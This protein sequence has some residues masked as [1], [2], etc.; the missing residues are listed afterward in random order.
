[1]T[2]V[3]SDIKAGEAAVGALDA[4]DDS[5][6]AEL[7]ARAQAGGVKLTG[8]GGLL[9]ELTRK[10]LESA[11]EGELTDHL[12]HEPG[13]R[14]EGGRENYRNGHRSK[15]VTTEVGPVEIAVPRDRAGTFE[16]QLVKK[17]Q[18]R[19]GGVD[20]MVL[21]LSA[22]GLTHGEISA[23]L[24]E[25]YGTEV[26]KTT[27]STI[28][29]SVMAGMAEWQNRPLDS[30]YPVVFIDCVNVKVRDGQVANR[31][32]YMALAVTAEGHR[33]ILGLWV[34]DG[35]EGAKYWLQV[36]TE[37]KNRGAR[38]VLMLVCDGLTG[39][40]DAVNTVWPA[41]IVQTC[42][43]HLLRNSFRYAARQD[44]EK[45][46]KA[47]KP[48]YTAPTEDAALER[49]MEFNEAW[50]RKY[51]A[52]VRLWES[53][54]AEFVPFLQFDIEIRKIVC[55]TNAIES[56][57]ARIRKAVRARGHFPTEQAALKCVY[58]AVMSLDPKGTG[59]KRWTMR[60]KAALQAFDIT[61]DGRLT[62]GRR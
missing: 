19:L 4:V 14:V 43:V 52:I 7:V 44:W 35:G 60:W 30:V 47:L 1:M 13:E 42:V 33:D 18:R 2:D 36:L 38:D 58:L 55:T 53:A 27:V 54:W 41:T 62:A 28:T 34:G 10:V 17:R 48:I 6:V 12:G 22:K 21:S 15:T 57:N 8:E 11:L 59:S 23:H 39:L 56:V 16:P 25:V 49:F 37:I 20:E 40:P 3:M 32:V 45:I 24:A 50:G 5:L 26:S 31:P 9:A 29:D 46:A 61:F 51:P